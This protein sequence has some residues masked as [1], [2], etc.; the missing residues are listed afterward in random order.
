MRDNSIGRSLITATS[1][2]APDSSTPASRIVAVNAAGL[3]TDG[4]SVEDMWAPSLQGCSLPTLAW[5]FRI[6]T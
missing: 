6:A 3:A 4:K 1:E 2:T 5:I